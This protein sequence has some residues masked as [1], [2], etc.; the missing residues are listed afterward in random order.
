MPRVY[1]HPD[2][3]VAHLVRGALADAGIEAHVR[4]DHLGAAMG[5]VPPIAAWAEVWIRDAGRAEDA[6]AIV[7]RSTPREGEADAPSWACAS[8][9]ETVEGQF[10]ACWSCGAPAPEA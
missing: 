4:G 7:E 3:S 1:S 10:A 5:E 6:A 8:C 9:G 2:P